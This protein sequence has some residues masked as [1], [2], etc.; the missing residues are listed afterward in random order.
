[1]GSK[2]VL[3]QRLL[4]AEDKMKKSSF[5]DAQILAILKQNESGVPLAD[6]AGSPVIYPKEVAVLPTQLA[7]RRLARH[8][9]LS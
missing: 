8:Y 6:L 9:Y 5:S 4:D 1:M 2:I 7:T 3:L